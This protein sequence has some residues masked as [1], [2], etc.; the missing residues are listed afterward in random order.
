[1]T[2]RGGAERTPARG[3]V[4]GR[5]VQ[6]LLVPLPV[7]LLLATSG[8][9]TS[10]V[11]EARRSFYAGNP[12]QAAALL[13]DTPALS[14][15]PV[16]TLM[17]R[18]SFR[19]A[20]GDYEAS[21]RDW[22]KAIDT[23]DELDYLSVSRST[24]SL[25]VN[26]RLLAFRGEP[27]ERVLLHAFA[28]GSYLAM[29]IWDDA[30]VEARRI[31]RAL[32]NLDGFPDDPY[33]HYVAGFCFEMLDEPD[34]AAIEYGK[35]AKLLPTLAIDPLTGRIGPATNTTD[36]LICFVLVGRLAGP[37]AAAANMRWGPAPYAEFF[38]G[39]RY[40]GRSHVL[41]NV[42]HLMTLTQRRRA[43]MKTAKTVTRVVVKDQ[44]AH[45]VSD[46]NEMLGALTWLALFAM[47]QPDTRQWESL[48][49]H[50]EVARVPCPRDLKSY[51]VILKNSRGTA[52]EQR[53]ITAPIA[54]RGNIRFSFFRAL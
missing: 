10:R 43:A 30:A 8:C 44:V 7:L 47:E 52:I 24:G 39:D 54:R 15:E 17:E 37:G 45:A 1:M 26:D 5:A 16:L 42:R 18:G 20:S 51:T 6:V 2:R 38:A 21:V 35:V 53:A 34:D 14:K 3:R 22:L 9:A 33:S 36:E 48:P 23:A 31:A 19:Q 41:T 32:D 28:A 46:H 13:D 50:L 27:Y 12:A 25:L 29:G 40:L 11:E 4:A 49:L